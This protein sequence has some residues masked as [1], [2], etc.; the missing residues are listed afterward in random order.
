VDVDDRKVSDYFFFGAA[1]AALAGALP[2]P[3]LGNK[4]GSSYT[5]LGRIRLG[6]DNA[7]KCSAALPSLTI[8]IHSHLT[9]TYHII[10]YH[11]II[12]ASQH[13]LSRKTVVS[14]IMRWSGRDNYL[15]LEVY[16]A[17]S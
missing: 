2:L 5:Y 11:M 17:H 15:R 4:P 10:L 12:D 3:D 6:F 16:Y 1:A 13:K 7:A 8:P 14:A 9:Y